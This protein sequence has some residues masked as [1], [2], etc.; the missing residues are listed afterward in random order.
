[1]FPKPSVVRLSVDG[2]LDFRPSNSGQSCRPPRLLDFINLAA[3]SDETI[4]KA[5]GKYGKLLGYAM[6]KPGDW[7]YF[8]R[9]AECILAEGQALCAQVSARDAQRW[10]VLGRFIGIELKGSH[11]T[12]ERQFVLKLA[13]DRWFQVSGQ[14]K[15]QALWTGNTIDVQPIPDTLLGAI[16]L[17]LADEIRGRGSKESCFECGRWFLVD[18]VLPG[19]R[20]FC[21]KCG[22]RAAMKHVM[23]ERR[24]KS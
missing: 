24:R 18:R 12:I 6:E 17:A 23:R 1:M 15:I 21:P 19:R 9:I 14:F 8:A 3:A 22:R 5:A 2:F 4:V 7:R 11:G 16:G 20:R 13:L 10:D